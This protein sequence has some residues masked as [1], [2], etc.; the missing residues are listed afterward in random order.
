M[1]GERLRW[2]L[3][4][5]FRVARMTAIRLRHWLAPHLAT[6]V[7]VVAFPVLGGLAI[8]ERA[9][10]RLRRAKGEPPRVMWG[11]SPMLN[12]KYG[13]EA[14][15]TLGYESRTVAIAPL[16]IGKREDFDRY[17]DEFRSDYAM[18]AWALRNGD[19]FMMFFDLGFMRVTPLKWRELQLLRLA[20]KKVVVTAFGGDAAVAGELGEGVEGPLFTDYPDLPADAPQIRHRVEHTLKSAVSVKTH[21]PAFQPREDAISVTLLAIDTDEWTD[22]VRSTDADGT[23]GE[24]VVIHAPNHRHIKGT[25]FLERAVEQLN[26]EG[27]SVRLEILEGRPN[28]E[29]RAAMLACDIVADQFIL[30][31]ALFAI[32][33]MARGKPVMSNLSLVSERMRGLEQ[34]RGCPIVDTRPET[35][36]DELRR[37]VENP[38]LR[39]EIGEAGREF[40]MRYHSYEAMGNTWEALVEFAWNGRPL[41]PEMVP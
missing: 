1:S 2:A 12:N 17:R 31:Y 41:P 19:V 24:V 5:P 11:P 13:S 10:T 7:A 18:F 32:E 8:W 39:R 20:G 6:A 35:L 37:L 40:A 21:P 33:G 38:A 3:G 16:S 27:L 26:E 30:G 14:L 28:D 36:V 15:R 25:E 22:E 4:A 23:S 29:V 9:R 34:I